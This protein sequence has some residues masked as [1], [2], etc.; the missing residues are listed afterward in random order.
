M[1]LLYNPLSTTPGKQPLPLAL[2]ALAA[3]LEGR[4]P[5]TLVDGN[6][7]PDPAARIIE[8]ARTLPDPSKGLLAVT[9]MPG[10]QVAQAV[11]VCRRVRAEAPGLPIVW[12]G[13]FPTQHADVILQA[14]YV[15][16]VVRSQGELALLELLEVIQKGGALSAIPNLSWKEG[17]R[18]V[19][20]PLRPPSP[21]DD[22]PDMPYHRVRMDHYIHRNYLGTRT[23]AHWSSF[24]CPFAC[25]FCAVVAMSNRRWLAQSPARLERV[26]RHLAS[27]YGVNGLQMH[28]MDFFVSEARTAEYCERIADVGVRWWALGRVDTLMRY[29][30]ATWRKMRAAGLKMIF[31]GAESGSDETL[32]RMN[33]GG[34]ASTRLTLELVKRMREYGVV[35]ECSFV[36]GAPPD[37]L[38]DMHRTFEFIRELKRVNPAAEIILYVYT[39]VP[40][41]GAL[42]EEAQRLGFR[43]PE[44][45]EAW[46]SD[47]WR[48]LSLRKG[49][50]ILWMQGEVRR[51][52]RNFERVLNA[53]YPTVTDLRLT[54]VY[55]A[56]LKAL[57]VWRYHLRVYAA[58]Y[59]LRAMQ[60]LIRYQRPETTGF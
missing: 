20:N 21:P 19:D 54:G 22:F 49:D 24:G 35:P 16:F 58:P 11:P 15:D 57:S 43:F 45:L 30:D 13:Y 28:D 23:A 31:M 5:W 18:R 60:R 33:K 47:E 26:T 50:H 37:P 10:P 39:P 51:R 38:D 36:L 25:N 6:V 7:T 53:Y 27:A 29:S 14:P 8:V 44:T 2:M 1:I 52:V 56:L 55:R 3:V 12:G 40:L 48:Q 17:G 4:H 41:D 42:Y 34:R 32:A 59:E 46:A 9:V